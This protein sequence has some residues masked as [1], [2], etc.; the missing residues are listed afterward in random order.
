MSTALPTADLQFVAKVSHE[1]RGPLHAIL[2]LSELLL[3]TDL[4]AEQRRYARSSLREARAMGVMIDDIL[5]LARLTTGH[6][7]VRHDAFSPARLVAEIVETLRPSASAK[8]LSLLVMVE[9][10]V[11][12]RILGDEHRVGQIVRNLVSNAVRY[13]DRGSIDVEVSARE[14]WLHCAVR[15]TGIGIDEDGLLRLFSPFAQVHDGRSGGTG[16]GLAVS[17]ALAE[18]MG[19]RVDVESTIDEGSVF[20]LTIPGTATDVSEPAVRPLVRTGLRTGLILVVE[21][22]EVN[23]LLAERQLASLGFESVV[24]DSGEAALEWLSTHTPAAVL[25]DWNLPGI[26]G[27]ETTARIRTAMPHLAD[28][29]IIGVTANALTGDRERCLSVGMTDFVAKPVGLETL[30]AALERSLQ[31]PESKSEPAMP[32]HNRAVDP[33]VL[34]Q[35]E[36]ELG[37]VDTVAKILVAFLDELPQR[38]QTISTAVGN[39]PTTA[40]RAAHTLRSTAALLGATDLAALCRRFQDEEEPGALALLAEQIV[41]EADDVEQAIALRLHQEGTS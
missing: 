36:A 8:S 9:P 35:L 13:T 31:A 30:R 28:L 17:R 22:S 20:A 3:A 21:D 10:N 37:G 6:L 34:D 7:D 15:D 18:A 14:G 25:M 2:G 19:G 38:K 26:D 11:P 39:D 40:Q 41:A 27:L 12:Q 4:T 5:D 33:I 32:R 16:L 24:V 23:Q 1:L 29:P